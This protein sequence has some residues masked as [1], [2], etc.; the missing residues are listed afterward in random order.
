MSEQRISEAKQTLWDQ[1]DREPDLLTTTIAD[2]VRIPSLLGDEAPVQHY[3]ADSLVSSGFETE[4]WDLDDAILDQPNAGRSGVPFAGRP[5]VTGKKRGSGEGRSLILNGHIDVVSPEPVS[6]WTH[7]PWG[8]EIVD[9]RMFGRGSFDMK[10]GVGLN[11]VLPQMLARLG[12]DLG[13]DLMVH[14]V[15]EEECTGNGALAASL[16][17]SADAAIVTEPQFSSYTRAHL[18]VIWF[19]VHID[20]ISTHA[21]HAWQGVNA[22]VKTV[23]VIEALTALDQALNLQVDPIWEGIPHPINLNIG[24]IQGGDWPSTVPGSCDL[25]CRVSFFPSISVDEMQ[26]TITSAIAEAA[27]HDPWLHDHPPVVTFDGFRTAGVILDE[28]EPMLAALSSRPYR[29][30]QYGPGTKDRHGGQR[31]AVLH[32]QRRACDLLWRGGWQCSRC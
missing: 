17:D 24:V 4:T 23:P 3:V 18:G 26:A 27:R 12:I 1:I 10:S 7:D 6:A 19:R 2:L 20:G 8:A 32:L 21:G 14:S 29:G 30:F 15:I 13:A 9:N 11:L 25:H 5:N 16:R 22:I 28:T 31:H